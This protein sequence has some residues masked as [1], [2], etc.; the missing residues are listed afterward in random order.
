MHK[1]DSINTH[2]QSGHVEH[3]GALDAEYASPDA[4]KAPA[5]VIEGVG[6]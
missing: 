6:E 3:C 1:D 5:R 2:P 4:A